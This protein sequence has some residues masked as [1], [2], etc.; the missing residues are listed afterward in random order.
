MISLRTQM[1]ELRIILALACSFTASHA[2]A[3]VQAAP[4]TV[5][6]VFRDCRARLVAAP[7]QPRLAANAVLLAILCA[8]L[9]AGICA[10]V[11]HT[12]CCF[13]AREMI[14]I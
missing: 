13:V 10:T 4:H 11:A 3:Q 5:G 6:S 12:A 2:V 1:K 14:P 7:F 8:L 9:A